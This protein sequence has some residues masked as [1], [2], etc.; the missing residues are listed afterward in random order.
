MV[1]TCYMKEKISG[2]TYELLVAEFKPKSVT[3]QTKIIQEN[4]NV[5]INKSILSKLIRGSHDTN[6]A[7]VGFNIA[8][9]EGGVTK[10]PWC[11]PFLFSYF[12]YDYFNLKISVI[13]ISIFNTSCDA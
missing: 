6:L 12:L 7:L 1:K 8:G 11:N 3:Q 13:I 9:L 4:K 2:V 5:R 10:I